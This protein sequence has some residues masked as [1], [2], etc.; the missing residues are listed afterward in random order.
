MTVGVL[1]PLGSLWDSNVFIIGIPGH[2][3]VPVKLWNLILPIKKAL[4]WGERGL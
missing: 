2:A 4:S 3:E 1:C